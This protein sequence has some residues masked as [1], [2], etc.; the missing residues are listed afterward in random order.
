LSLV[1]GI[2]VFLGA[3]VFSALLWSYVRLSSAYE[4]D[5]DLPVKLTPPKGYAL[6][7]GLPEHLHTRVRGA[8]W[9]IML[10]SF[11]KNADY[12]FDLTDRAMPTTS[13]VILHNDEISH[14]AFLPSEVRVIK[15]EPDSLLLAF[16]KS[17]E[18]KLPVESRLDV[19][20][21]DGYTIVGAPVLV[22]NSVMVNGSQIV[23]DSLRSIPTKSFEVRNAKEDIERS[24][25]L[26]DT[27]SNQISIPNAPKIAV[28]VKVEALGEMK[29]TGVPVSIEALPPQYEMFLIPNT[30]TVTARGGVNELAKL[31]LQSIRAHVKYDPMVLDTAHT[32]APQ[33]E[34]PNGITFLGTE[35]SA[36][37]F[38]IR[39]KSPANA[40]P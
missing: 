1:R 12:Q 8:G 21:A 35:P 6:A 2:F 40:S 16:N 27:L 33:V 7:S 3:L 37:K 5:V 15:V 17:I 28:H 26:S 29:F 38:I 25:L 13:S 20:A 10:M 11:A 22:P 30:I 36:L 4:A 34:V 14:S 19:T 39:R 31:P 18:K 24:M 9:Q 23:L 32:V